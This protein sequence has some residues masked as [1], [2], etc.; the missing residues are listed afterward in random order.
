MKLKLITIL[1]CF[2]ILSN[3]AVEGP[4]QEQAADVTVAWDAYPLEGHFI[5]IYVSDQPGSYLGATR[6]DTAVGATQ[7]TIIGLD[8]AVT[9]YFVATAVDPRGLESLPTEELSLP[10]SRAGIPLGFTIREVKV[11]TT[12]RPR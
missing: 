10:P 4:W 9:W 12:L 11:S 5:R 6:I 3:A 7:F 2:A 1:S 8:P